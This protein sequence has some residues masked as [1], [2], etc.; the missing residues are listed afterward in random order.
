MVV[1]NLKTRSY[2]DLPL[3]LSDCDI[4]HRFERSGALHGLLRVQKF[5]QDDA[6]IFLTEEQLEAE[7]DAALEICD[8]FYRIFDLKYELRLGTRPAKFIGDVETWD[9]AEAA[10]RRILDKHVGTGKYVVKN[11]DGAFYGPKIDILMED[12]LGRSWQMGTIQLD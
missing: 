3:R 10:L 8:L 9:R 5:Q 2:R 6:H 7:Y 11:G 4:L 1:F 12:T